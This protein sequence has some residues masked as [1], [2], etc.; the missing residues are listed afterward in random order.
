M[1]DTA[2]LI[3]GLYRDAAEQVRELARRSYLTD[4]RSDLL[5][6]S[7]RFERLAAYADA[8]IRLGASGHPHGGVV[9]IPAE[10][11][12]DGSPGPARMTVLIVEDDPEVADMI[13]LLLEELGY[14]VRLAA[15]AGQALSLVRRGDAIDLVFSDI[16]MPGGLNGVDLARTMRRRFPQIAV[17]LTTGYGI[18]A[19]TARE[20][21]FAI[22]PKPYC[23]DLLDQ[24]IRDVLRPPAMTA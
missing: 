15:D 14:E 9:P 17:L 24:A 18:E 22:L 8:A 3:P 11:P 7:A 16:V 21:G 5:E 19:G 1:G 4:V 6:L 10:Y 13:A 2:Q 20:A 23:P 12:S